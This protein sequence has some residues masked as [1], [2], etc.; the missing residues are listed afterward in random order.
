M[1]ATPQKIDITA[2]DIEQAQ[3]RE[4]EYDYSDIEVPG[5]Y[6]AT[7][8]DVNDHETERG[9]GWRFTFEIM[10]C[11]F[12]EYTMFSKKAKWKLLQVIEA[13]GYPLEEG[14]ADFD[15]NAYVGVVVGAHVD[16]QHDPD[17][18]DGANYREIKYVFPYDPD[19]VAV[20]EDVEDEEATEEAEL[21]EPA[22]I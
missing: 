19:E 16:W 14:I 10:G 18:H 3:R 5:D 7:L 8:V 4:S 13:L 1:P 9:K 15:P 22:I 17:E 2:K 12:D 6:E 21:E 11:P 20:E